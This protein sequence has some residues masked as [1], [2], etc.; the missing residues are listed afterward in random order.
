M[1]TLAAYSLIANYSAIALYVLAFLAFVGDLSARSAAV[2]AGAEEAR[3]LAREQPA[4]RDVGARTALLERLARPASD[5]GSGWQRLGFALTVL[6][7]L[8]HLAALVMRGVAAERV[9]WANMYEFA[10][11]GTAL[12][13]AVF[14]GVQLWR[15]VRFLGAYVTGI[16][17]ILLALATVNF[18]VAV[19]PLPPPLQ[20]IWLVI[21]VFVATLATGF[22]AIGGGLSI[23]Q[24]LQARR[25]SGRAAGLRF[26]QT[27]PTSDTLDR[28]ASRVIVVGFALWTFTLMA[29]A[30]WAERAWGRY[31]GWDTKEV[32]TF[33]VWVVFAGYIHARA[34]K[35]WRGSRSAWLAI[36]GFAAVLFNFTAVN[37]LFK[38]LHAYS[39]L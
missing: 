17:S 24:L 7:W 15:D 20:S 26:L 5:R 13:V 10:L 30:I 34:T 3:A 21:H 28:L 19:S 11:T 6:G 39:G 36:V 1:D 23:A 27:F 32:W 8:L 25:E 2:T 37:L 18:Y 22:F 14:L 12:A 38:G 31:W 16:A 4:E 29:G 33:I 35:G 9:P